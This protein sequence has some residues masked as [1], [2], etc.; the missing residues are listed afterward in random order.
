MSNSNGCTRR[1]FV[2][3]S[4]GLATL[5]LFPKDA[6]AAEASGIGAD[7]VS[8]LAERKWAEAV[9]RAANTISLRMQ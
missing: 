8:N 7:E 3:G 1:D 9:K 6:R 4:F 2:I 5:G